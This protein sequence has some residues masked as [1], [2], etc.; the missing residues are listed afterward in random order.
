MKPKEIEKLRKSTSKKFIRAIDITMA[1]V[2]LILLFG[3]WLNGYYLNTLI[4][5]AGTTLTELLD[6][7]L[8]GTYSGIRMK[9]HEMLFLGLY[10]LSNM[11]YIIGGWCLAKFLQRRNKRILDYIDELENK[12]TTINPDADERK[13]D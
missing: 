10:R 6:Y 8:L 5:K 1:L 4:S 13:K 9:A 7:D 12:V 3:I 2:V 11:I